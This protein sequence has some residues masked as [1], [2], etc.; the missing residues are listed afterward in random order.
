MAKAGGRSSAL[1]VARAEVRGDEPGLSYKSAV[2]AESDAMIA[3]TV[4]A[5]LLDGHDAADN[6]DMIEP[7]RRIVTPLIELAG[8]A[9]GT[10]YI[11]VLAVYPEFRGQGVGAAL[12]DHTA[13]A[14]IDAGAREISLIVEDDNAAVPLYRRSGFIER[15]R[16]PFVPFETS[17]KRDGH[18][19][20]MVRPL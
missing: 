2:I 20:L 5:Y 10:W 19:V 4:I 14:G 15:E 7:V 3:G 12:L 17:T 13:R 9:S 16:R 6:D 11:N 8:A 1:E 18:W